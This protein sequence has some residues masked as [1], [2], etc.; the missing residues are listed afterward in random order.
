MTSCCRLGL[1]CCRL[2]L[3]CV[4]LLVVVVGGGGD[5]VV[6]ILVEEGEVLVVSSWSFPHHT[7]FYLLRFITFV[8]EGPGVSL[9]TEATPPWLQRKAL[10]AFGVSSAWL[11]PNVPREAARNAGFRNGGSGALNDLVGFF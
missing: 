2:G 9:S 11:L 10:T 3:L 1:L 4:L 6:A 8:A 7:L 5:V